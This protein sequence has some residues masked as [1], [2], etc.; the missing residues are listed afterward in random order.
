MFQSCFY[1]VKSFAD[2]ITSHFSHAW[3]I[4]S[5]ITQRNYKKTEERNQ[6][7]KE[8]FNPKGLFRFHKDGSDTKQTKFK[9]PK[10]S[11]CFYFDSNI[12]L[13]PNA[14]LAVCEIVNTA[15]LVRK[16]NWCRQTQQ[17][18]CLYAVSWCLR[19]W[20]ICLTSLFHLK[21]FCFQQKKYLF[22]KPWDWN[23]GWELKFLNVT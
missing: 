8:V 2:L 13:L 4:G 7:N 10:L 12:C 3:L 23:I 21:S 14:F 19:C 9:E 5:K 20:K 17:S 16:T 11:K 15:A 6:N 22:L 1:S 18:G